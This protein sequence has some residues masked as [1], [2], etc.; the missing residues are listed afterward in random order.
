MHRIVRIVILLAV[1]RTLGIGPFA[2]DGLASDGV[3]RLFEHFLG[4][5]FVFE[6]NKT[7]WPTLLFRLVDRCFDLSNLDMRE[8]KT[9]EESIELTVPN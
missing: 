2:I 9:T 4:A 7:E 3:S 5:L 8:V 6:E 1:L